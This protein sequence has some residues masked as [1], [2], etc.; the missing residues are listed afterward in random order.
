MT[1]HLG[2][3]IDHVHLRVA[4][5]AASRTFYSAVCD[6]LHLGDVFKDAA[7]HFTIDEIYVD[8]A[9]DYVSRIHLAFQARSRD[10]VDAF[11]SRA[12]QAGGTS[13]GAPGLRPYHDRYYAAFVLDPDGN[14]IEAVCD[15]PNARSADSV[16]VE[17]P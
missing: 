5:L 13:N 4:D 1:Y 14:N 7:D 3:V 10:E 11:Y 16:T 6:A 12:I 9:E 2:R 17:R 8:A 15:A